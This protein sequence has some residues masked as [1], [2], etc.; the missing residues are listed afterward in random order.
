MSGIGACELGARSGRAVHHRGRGG[1]G[2]GGL[3]VKGSGSGRVPWSSRAR[4]RR[5]PGRCASGRRVLLGDA[6]PQAQAGLAAVV[7]G[8]AAGGVAVAAVE[9]AVAEALEA[10]QRAALDLPP[11]GRAADAERGRH[12]LVHVPED[13]GAKRPGGTI[14]PKK[15]SRASGDSQSG[16]W[17]V[18]SS[19][20]SLPL[21]H[22]GPSPS[23]AAWNW[24]TS[25][26]S[27]PS[28]LAPVSCRKALLRPTMPRRRPSL[29]AP[30][31]SR[32]AAG[33]ACAHG[34]ERV[35]SCHAV[36]GA[37]AWSTSLRYG[38]EGSRQNST[39]TSG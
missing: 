27:L 3:R 15:C 4:R 16:G 7:D 28:K 19:E 23:Q 20:K 11:R 12:V 14:S 38:E 29:R 30:S 22:A 35:A 33:R 36:Y 26:A 18:I 9:L 10:E 32:R 25:T 17:C 2:G 24:R 31:R 37:N 21:T 1:G 13:V 6:R 34:A 39:W 8:D 5:G